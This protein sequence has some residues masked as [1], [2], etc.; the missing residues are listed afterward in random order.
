MK[1]KYLI[2]PLLFIF[3]SG[4]CNGIMDTIDHHWDI[5]VFNCLT[6]SDFKAW[7]GNYNDYDVGDHWYRF[8]VITY[9]AEDAWHCAK[10]FM[11]LFAILSFIAFSNRNYYLLPHLY[12]H[13][14]WFRIKR[15]YIYA[16]ILVSMWGAGKELFYKIILLQ[17]TW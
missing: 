14:L 6:E 16:L 3:L 13:I 5:S 15:L 2:L 1:L 4:M 9:A 10:A 17:S 8:L 7:L 12:T 11:G